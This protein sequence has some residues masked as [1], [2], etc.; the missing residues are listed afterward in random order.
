MPAF[1]LFDDEIHS[2]VLFFEAM[3]GRSQPLEAQPIEKSFVREEIAIPVEGNVHPWVK[4]Y[5]AVLANLYFQLVAW[6]ELY[7]TSEQAV[8]IGPKGSKSVTFTFK[9]S[10]AAVD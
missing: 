5:M 1:H 4:V 9:A 7:G 3:S 6:H 8:T 10:A 2:L